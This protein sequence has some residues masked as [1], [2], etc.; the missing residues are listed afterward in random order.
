MSL[1]IANPHELRERMTSLYVAQFRR[2]YGVEMQR[3]LVGALVSSQL[4]Y[5]DS[6]RAAG[7]LRESTSSAPTHVPPVDKRILA[8]PTDDRPPAPA[9]DHGDRPVDYRPDVLFKNPMHI[10]ERFALAMGRMA[11]IC[12]GVGVAATFGVAST[13]AQM[14]AL[15]RRFAD[16]YAWFMTRDRPAPTKGVDHN[17]YRG[18]TDRDAARAFMRAIEDIADASSGRLG[19]WRVPK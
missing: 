1:R 3:D 6:V 14:P 13:T 8:T 5:V 16:H 12:E 18:M 2:A 17:P 15:A 11:R 7:D 9:P 4:A 19:P 10:G